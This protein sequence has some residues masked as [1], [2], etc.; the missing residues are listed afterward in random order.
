M[1]KAPRR[2]PTTR[3]RLKT[4]PVIRLENERRFWSR[5]YA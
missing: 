2:A 5:E 1:N 3:T 4:V